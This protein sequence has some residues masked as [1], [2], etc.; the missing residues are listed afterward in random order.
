[1]PWKTSIRAWR[2]RLLK[3]QSPSSSSQRSMSPNRWP[4]C[5]AATRC[6]LSSL[7]PAEKALA[8]S[9]EGTVKVQEFHRQLF[10]NSADELRPEIKRITGVDEVREATTE[11]EITSGT[12]VQVF[13]DAA[14]LSKTRCCF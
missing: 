2:S 9:R 12:V 8:Q 14:K 4:W 7:S 10:S 6:R 1:M 3:R 11:V 5:S 13:L